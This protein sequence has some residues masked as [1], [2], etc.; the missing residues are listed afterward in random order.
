MYH[1][2]VHDALRSTIP[3]GDRINTGSGKVTWIGRYRLVAVTQ[4]SDL[5]AHERL[6]PRLQHPHP[7]LPSLVRLPGLGFQL[8]RSLSDI[9]P[10]IS[11][12]FVENQLEDSPSFGSPNIQEPTQQLVLWKR[13]HLTHGV[14]VLDMALARQTREKQRRRRI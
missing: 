11:S 3:C 13:Y 8:S 9:D 7:P 4:R 2:I 6:Y 12:S 5:Y 1:H 14:Y 10:L